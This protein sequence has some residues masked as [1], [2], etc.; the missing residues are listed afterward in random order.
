M[1]RRVAMVA[2]A[3]AMAAFATT[4]QAASPARASFA[5]VGGEVAVPY[6]WVDFCGRQ[7]QECSQPALPP[8]DVKLDKTTLRVLD[9]VNRAV[10]A[11]IEPVSNLDHW[12]TVLDHWDYPVDG[13]GDCKI[14]ALQKRKLLMER[15]SRARRC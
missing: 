5:I 14:Y 6:G 12:G 13:K 3:A 1:S 4:P 11:A 10:N 7:P 9:A 15:E 2:L 8:R